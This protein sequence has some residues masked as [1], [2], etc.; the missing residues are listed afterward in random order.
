MRPCAHRDARHGRPARR[1]E[2]APAFCATA[3]ARRTKKRG[4]RAKTCPC[5][6]RKRYIC[7]V[8]EKLYDMKEVMDFLARLQ[9]NNNREWFRA[10]KD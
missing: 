6:R 5:Q 9:A 1:R 8:I 7:S 10:Q 4:H 2:P 3:P